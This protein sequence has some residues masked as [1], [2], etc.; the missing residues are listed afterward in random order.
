MFKNTFSKIIVALMLIL[1]AV[2]PI[3]SLYYI[4]ILEQAQYQP[5]K[6]AII[7]E[8]LAYGNIESII[9]MDLQG[10]ISISGTV[11]STKVIYEELDYE[12]ITDIRLLVVSGQVLQAG[13][14]I[15]YLNGHE[16][17]ATK[18]G[19]IRS[20]KLSG[21]SYIELWSIDDLVIEC[22]VNET[23]LNIL[24]RNNLDLADN[25]NN[26]F[27]VAQI[28]DIRTGS[29]L[30]RVLLTSNSATLIYG[31][32]ITD[33]KLTTGRIY[34]NCLVV[35]SS[36]VYSYNG[37][38]HFIRSVTAEGVVMEELQ[39][40]IGVVMNNFTCIISGAEEGL[41][42]DSGYKTIAEGDR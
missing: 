1:T 20:I 16:V 27:S 11:I 9:R 31:Q 2:A 42:C 34:P 36:C 21:D 15:G 6:D 40:E 26:K 25:K 12:N 30:T 14:L 37:Q 8:E 24:N 19:V 23:V 29:D 35:D 17:R 4:S 39:V 38:T 33:F 41:L 18:T 22:Y 13:D 5:Q 7:L 32:K 3:C 28:D 10:D